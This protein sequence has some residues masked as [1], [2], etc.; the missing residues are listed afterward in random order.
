MLNSAGNSSFCDLV[1]DYLKGI[2]PINL[3]FLIFW[4]HTA[5]F[6]F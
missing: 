2:R 1:L 4:R 5:S 6:K 3:D